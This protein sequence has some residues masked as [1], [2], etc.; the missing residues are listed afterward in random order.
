MASQRN[1]E[2]QEYFIKLRSMY[3]AQCESM[4]EYFSRMDQLLTREIAQ[5][6]GLFE[7][8]IAAHVMEDSRILDEESYESE[9][10]VFLFGPARFRRLIRRSNLVTVITYFES[11]L[12]EIASALLQ[13][14]NMRRVGTAPGLRLKDF[15][16]NNVCD[17]CH[18]V[19]TR[20]I[21]V[22]DD[23]RLWS[24]LKDYIKLRNSIVHKAGFVSVVHEKGEYVPEDKLLRDSHKKISSKGFSVEPTGEMIIEPK[25]LDIIIED[26]RQ[27]LFDIC[28]QAAEHYSR[29]RAVKS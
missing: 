20:Y 23:S 8:D 16:P 1:F 4:L 13:E 2:Y 5:E 26:V 11:S 12:S 3:D 22:A 9:G 18:T 14:S 6:R 24:S 15:G 7:D 17:R 21:G 10:E 25:M 27:Y 19:L 29:P 28:T